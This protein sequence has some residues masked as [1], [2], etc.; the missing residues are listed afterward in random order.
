[1]LACC[2]LA[3]PAHAKTAE[4]SD[5]S[6]ACLK[7]HEKPDIAAKKLEDGKTLSMH[8]RGADYL[9]AQHVEQDCT[10]CHSD[11]DDKTHGKV[12]TPLASRRALMESM[13]ET[14]RDCHKKR[15]KLYDD[16]LHA[17]LVK[18]GSD[19]APLC[20]NCHDAHYQA[21]VKLLE[22][23]DKTSCAACHDKV[24][25]AYKADVHGLARVA[26]G[27][28]S[29]ICADCHQSHDNKAASLGDG[30]KD[31]CLKC[32]KDSADKHAQW[33]PNT[34][35]HFEA[36]SCVTCHSP[37][38]KRRVNLR[39]YDSA[40]DTQLREKAGVP[41]FVQRVK[42]EDVANVGLTEA[43]LDS[44]LEQFGNE[45]GTK[46]KV[47]LRG[48]LEVQ[49]GVEAHQLAPKDKA[50]KACDACH[51]LGS[52]AF[53]SVVLSIA[54]AD[55][56]PLRHAVQ[57]QVLGSVT[58]FDSVRGF[59]ALGSTRIKLL[60]WLLGLAVAGSI[61]GCLAHMTARRLTRGLRE[62]RAAASNT[63]RENP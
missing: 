21:S 55:G 54:S 1:M 58:A 41:Q 25:A 32:H 37:D 48:R 7:C 50:L 38:A 33:L 5:E 17:A 46:R 19:K 11:L 6:K 43:D 40:T 16:G 39:L 3:G 15:Q 30:Q 24:F 47:F 9:A 29:P 23:I 34:A 61:A 36:I 13:Q 49:S 59:Y 18:Q 63:G 31:T 52:A 56:R 45:G 26:K 62:R 10:D 53:E 60:D 22:P 35:L 57:N 20:A 2:L 42:A 28:D 51:R 12:S 8:I 4:F 14:C 44:L 27:K